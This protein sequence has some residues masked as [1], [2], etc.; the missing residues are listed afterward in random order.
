MARNLGLRTAVLTS[1]G[2][3]LPMHDLL[4]GIDVVVVPSAASTQMRNVYDD[5]RRTQTVPSV[6]SRITAADVP[7]EW[8]AAGV[9]LLGP[10]AGEVDGEMVS[11]FP[12]SLVGVGAQGWLREIGEGGKVRQVQ[13]DAWDASTVVGS[14]DALF[15]SD[16]DLAEEDYSEALAGW[17]AQVPIV[18]F[19]RGDGGADV[20]VEGEWRRVAAFAAEAVDPTGAG[21]VFA[22][23][24]LVRYGETKDA[25]EAAALRERGG[26]AGGGGRGR[27]R[28][29]GAGGGGGAVG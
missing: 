12:D 4:P 11:L 10:V 23:A 28:R 26:V 8:R 21:D 5:G 20:C 25:W 17:A 16:E 29:A 22:T 14:A 15:L 27:G 19:T 1:R 6:A 24:F 2:P 9:V 18:C 3:D 13:H 7:D